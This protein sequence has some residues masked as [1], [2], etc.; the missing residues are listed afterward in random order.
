MNLP[1][2][3]SISG[4]RVVHIVGSLIVGTICI[5]IFLSWVDKMVN[6][7]FAAIHEDRARAKNIPQKVIVVQ[8]DGAG[9]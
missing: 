8:G 2:D 6:G 3:E 9:D 4:V 5:C 1:R 7:L